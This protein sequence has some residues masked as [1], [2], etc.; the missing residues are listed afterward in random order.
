[1]YGIKTRSRSLN[2]VSRAME[3]LCT[4]AVVWSGVQ[5]LSLPEK[6][7]AVAEEFNH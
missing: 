6:G 3:V 1:M 2:T 5:R 7:R 4:A